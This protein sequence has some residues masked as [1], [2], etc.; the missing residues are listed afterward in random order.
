MRLSEIKCRNSLSITKEKVV[1]LEFQPRSLTPEPI[2]Y[3]FGCH[4]YQDNVS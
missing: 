1:K 4:P 3:P 2:F